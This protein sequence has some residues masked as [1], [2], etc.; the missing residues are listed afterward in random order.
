MFNLI[1]ELCLINCFCHFP[2][3]YAEFELSPV[4]CQVSEV[5]SAVCGAEFTVWLTSVEGSSIL[6]VF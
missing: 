3:F 5:K 6:Y 4:R 1:M 2:Y